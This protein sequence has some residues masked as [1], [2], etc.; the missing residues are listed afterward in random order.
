MKISPSYCI[1]NG[2]TMEPTLCQFNPVS[3]STKQ[4]SDMN[5]L[6]DIQPDMNEYIKESRTCYKQLHTMPCLDQ[7]Y[8]YIQHV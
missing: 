4:L 2:L 8:V 1:Y 6:T 5:I 7:S 3:L